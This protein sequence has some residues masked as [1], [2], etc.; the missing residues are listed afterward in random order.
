MIMCVIPARAGS[1]RIP[2]KNIR[3]L[4]GKPVMAHSIECAQDSGLFDVVAVSTD[5]TEIG[6]IAR[7]YGAN[8]FRR[9][10]Q[11]A[12]DTATDADVIQEI[13]S[14]SPCDYLCYLYP[15]APLIEPHHLRWGYNAVRGPSWKVTARGPD[16]R[17]AGAFYWVDAA[18]FVHGEYYSTDADSVYLPDDIVCDVNTED[19]WTELE[20]KYRRLHAF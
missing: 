9:D 5:S 8:F 10:P 2:G 11:N 17:D 18:R 20:R 3:M 12:S 19:D 13:L 7:S 1:K 4:G 16:G 14:F 15:I 6:L